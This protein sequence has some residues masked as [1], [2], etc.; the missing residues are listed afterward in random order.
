[1]A[2][3]G[4]PFCGYSVEFSPFHGN[5]LAVGTAQY[6]GIVGNGRLQVM[7]IA[8]GQ[9]VPVCDWLSQDG[10]YDVAWSEDNEHVIASAHGDG[11]VKLFD[12]KNP[13]G[14][15]ASY[16]EHTAEVY[17]VD[18]NLNMKQFICSA[19]WDKTIKV[20]DVMASRCIAT[21]MNHTNIAYAAIWAPSKPAVLASVAGDAM[22]H[23]MDVNV[24]PQPVHSLQ[25]HQH[26]VLA[27]DWS[28]YNEFQIVTG[29]VD[30]TLRV[31]DLRNPAGPLQILYGHQLA[32]RRVKT[33]PHLENMVMSCSY[34]MSANLWDI[35]LGQMVDHFDHH[36][37]FVLGIDLNLFEENLVA[38]ASW[39]RTVCVWNIAKG[40]PGPPPP[41]I[42]QARR[43]QQGPP[44]AQ[45]KQ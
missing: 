10:I 16:H 25:A 34:D 5:L 11:S 36:T 37:E 7:D 4:T 24:G 30:K 18:W 19:S 22:L 15:I 9:P 12:L 45:L 35:N 1:M 29:S 31:F 38:T 13:Q 17:G 41:N 43:G 20:W 8:S 28:K 44:Q 14:P 32:V 23:V 27:V 2:W 42:I 3:A 6:F 21:Y 40:R 39:D 26:E 33:H